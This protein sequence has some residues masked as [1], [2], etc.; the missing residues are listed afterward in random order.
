M[1]KS[2]DTYQASLLLWLPLLYCLNLLQGSAAAAA[3][4]AAAVVDDDGGD[5][6]VSALQGTSAAREVPLRA[7]AAQ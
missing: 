7:E 1:K 2:W 4:A 3:A 6:D 5:G